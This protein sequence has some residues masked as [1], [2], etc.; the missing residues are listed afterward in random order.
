MVEIA[1]YTDRHAVNQPSST[2]TLHHHERFHSA[3]LSGDRDVI[4]WLPPGYEEGSRRYPALYMHDGQNLFDPET[5][6]HRGHHWRIGETAAELIAAGRV[7]PLIVVGI[8]NTGT[9]R[10]DEYTPTRDVKLGGGH[11]DDYGRLIIDEL[12]PFVDAT[13]RT[14]PEAK[15][16][17]IGGSSLGGLVTLHLGFSHP[18]TFSRMAALSPSVWWDHRAILR[19]VKEAAPRP[20]LR[21]WVDMGTAEGKAGL[22]DARLL[23]A[24]LVH[25]GW[26]DGD[27]LHY[28]EYEGADH[29]EGAWAA[30]FGPVLEW[31][32]PV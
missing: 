21:I 19:T 4:V 25:A 20:P 9:A 29:S 22:D 5:A 8:Y 12:K 28:A 31:L 23:H 3:Y 14:K 16:T 15:H 17:A 27:D 13:Y 2:G 6:F 30:R 7:E 18:Q 1:S 32:F 24:A 26:R 11:A 10:I